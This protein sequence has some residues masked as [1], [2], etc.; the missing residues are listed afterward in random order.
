[1]VFCSSNRICD[2]TVSWTLTDSQE[3]VT[4]F[5]DCDNA[6]KALIL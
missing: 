1:M 6:R 3:V 4:I 2:T 5:I